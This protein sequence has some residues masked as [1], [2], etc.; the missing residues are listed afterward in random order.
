MAKLRFSEALGRPIRIDEPPDELGRST[1]LEAYDAIDRGD[2]DGGQAPARV[3]PLRAADH[4]GHLRRLDLGDAH[5]GAAGDRR[6][7]GRADHARDA[8]LVG[9]ARATRTTSTSSFDERL[10]LTVEG[11]RGHLSGPGRLGNIDVI[12][13][14]NRVVVAFDPCGSG[15]RARRGDPARGIPPA[16]ERPEFGDSRGGPRLDLGQRKA[17]ASTAR[18]AR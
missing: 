4:P 9:G 13:E 15:G 18:T 1:L 6:A 17:S 5:V 10:A 14:G 16:A 8:R 3:V 7:R 2:G 11:M 12:D